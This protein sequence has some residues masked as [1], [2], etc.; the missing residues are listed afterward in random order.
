[1]TSTGQNQTSNDES[2][3]IAQGWETYRAACFVRP[4]LPLI[5]VWSA[6]HDFDLAPAGLHLEQVSGAR[7]ELGTH[8]MA[9]LLPHFA[10][11]EHHEW[12]LV[13]LVRLTQ[14][15][16]EAI[17]PAAAFD[18]AHRVQELRAEQAAAQAALNERVK[19]V[20]LWRLL[21]GSLSGLIQ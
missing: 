18:L 11:P 6:A 10:S 16:L 17:Q 2:A 1:M 13:P 4:G 12:H 20:T 14:A 19:Q 9:L 21:P 3:A 7:I 15:S 5:W 8:A